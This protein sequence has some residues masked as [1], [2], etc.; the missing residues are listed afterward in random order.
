MTNIAELRE[1]DD[2]ELMLRYHDLVQELVALKFQKAT[3]QLDNTAQTGKL[4]HDLARIKTLV[5]EREREQGLNK[6][7]LAAAVGPLTDDVGKGYSKIQERFGN[8]T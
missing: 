2:R 5:R 6:G 1:L 3:G 7:G 4:R 8:R